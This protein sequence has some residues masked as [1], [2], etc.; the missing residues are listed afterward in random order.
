MTA[1][2]KVVLVTGGAGF[3][4]RHVC[5]RLI[6]QGKTYVI[7]LDNLVTGNWSNIDD[8]VNSPIYSPHFHFVHH[9]IT[10]PIKLE[11]ILPGLFNHVDEIYHLACIASPDKYKEYAIETL[12]TS[13]Q[14]TKNVLDL[15]KEFT[16]QGK[17]CKVLFTST[18][19]VYGDPLV[20]P[21]PEDYYGN[22]NTMGE[23]SC[24]DEGKRVAETL[25]YEYRRKYGLD[26]KIVRLFNTYG[27]YM[28]INDGRVITNFI[29]Q[30]MANKP[31]QIYGDGSQ[32]RS[33]CYVDDLICGLF[34]MMASQEVGP[35]NLGNPYCEF[36]LNQLVH[37]FEKVVG[38]K[39][40]V[41]YLS[42]TENDPKQRK[43]DITKAH[44]ALGFSPII[45]LE[46]GLCILM[47]HFCN[48]SRA[49]N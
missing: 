37:V 15:A 47:N 13:F 23:R 28:D 45:D 11:H 8:F 4:G 30:I 38:Q 41:Q 16:K 19:E 29:K 31:V 18:S 24:Y 44:E 9:D 26:V 17:I 20:H 42:A 21:Q 40:Q 46:D 32:T 10:R 36:T 43:P 25:I 49:S 48:M 12:M 7:C 39:V 22:V 6:K 35:I 27:P 2:E 3:L 33:F 5:E 34:A 1:I 14:G